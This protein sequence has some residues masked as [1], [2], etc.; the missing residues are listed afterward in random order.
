MMNELFLI[1]KKSKIPVIKLAEQVGVSRNRISQLMVIDELPRNV[2]IATLDK[3]AAG[4]G[5]RVEIV[6][7]PLEENSNHG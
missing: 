1:I 4:V 5:H 3:I 6:F 2:E 7:V